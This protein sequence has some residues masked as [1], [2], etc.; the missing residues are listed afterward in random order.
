MTERPKIALVPGNGLEI[1]Q[2]RM[3]G[4]KWSLLKEESRVRTKLEENWS[5]KQTRL[6]FILKV[7]EHY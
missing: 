3:K 6:S 1:E 4:I 5:A 2:P 7:I